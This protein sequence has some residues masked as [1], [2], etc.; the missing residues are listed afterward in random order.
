MGHWAMKMCCPLLCE[1]VWAPPHCCSRCFLTTALHTPPPVQCMPLWAPLP[2]VLGVPSSAAPWAQALLASYSAWLQLPL[3]MHPRHP[4]P[5]LFVLHPTASP[6][7]SEAGSRNQKTEGELGYS[8]C[9]CSQSNGGG[10]R[11]SW[12]ATH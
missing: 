1:P 10:S 5:Q 9:C 7:G 4:T 11:E 12:G 6:S 2:A 8:S 3:T